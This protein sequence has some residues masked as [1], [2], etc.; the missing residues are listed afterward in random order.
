VPVV[1]PGWPGRRLTGPNQQHLAR[2]VIDDKPRMRAEALGTD[3]SFSITRHDQQVGAR[4]RL[5]HLSLHPSP[6]GVKPGGA[7]ESR[8]RGLQQRLRFLGGDRSQRGAGWRR[9]TAP[10][11]SRGAARRNVL[12]IGWGHVQERELGIFGHQ[13]TG[14]IDTC[15]PSALRYPDDRSH[16]TTCRANHKPAVEA[17]RINGTVRTPSRVNSPMSVSSS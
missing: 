3:P 10:Q 8:L 6:A 11:Q 4:A 17:T 7:A 9:R 12:D 1:G 15:L 14:P 13:L 16:H 5:H 2:R